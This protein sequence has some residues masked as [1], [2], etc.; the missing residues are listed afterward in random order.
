MRRHPATPR[1]L[2][3]PEEFQQTLRMPLPGGRAY[4]RSSSPD[5]AR[6]LPLV[7]ALHGVRQRPAALASDSRLTSYARTHGFVVAYGGGTAGV[8]NAGRCCQN[9]VADDV[10]YLT[11][12]VADV[13]RHTA[14]DRR[15]IYLVGF[16]NGGMMALRAL[17]ERPD[18]F[19]A[20]GVM[21]GALMTDCAPATGI[22]RI[23]LRIRQLHG[24]GDT[25]VP[26][27]GGSSRIV[28][29]LVPP[30]D[31]EAAALP[32]G[33]QL[34]LT[35]IPGLGHQWATPENSPFDATDQIWQ[36]LRG[37]ALAYRP[38]AKSG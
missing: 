9:D 1:P 4:Y 38:A 16:S 12:V 3:H 14:I 6:P 5:P 18:V 15:R 30:L 31:K 28:P 8:W 19:A 24:L 20:A 26:P 2:A 35:L 27:Q 7:I 34:D 11:E 33:S 13:E 23:P 36:F 21:S 37:K 32:A 17:C 25:T 29:E 10:H 22:R